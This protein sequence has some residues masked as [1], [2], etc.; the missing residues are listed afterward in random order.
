M[1]KTKFNC[2]KRFQT[3][4]LFASTIAR[5]VY[6]QVH[7]MY[8]VE[9]VCTKALL[10]MSLYRRESLHENFIRYKLCIVEKVCTKALHVYIERVCAKTLY[11]RYNMYAQS[12]NECCEKVLKT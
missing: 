11:T 12:I 8:I 4:Y 1:Q 3:F 7:M 2:S 6:N 5:E 9:K 10:V